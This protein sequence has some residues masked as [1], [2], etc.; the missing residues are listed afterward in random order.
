MSFAAVLDHTVLYILLLHIRPTVTTLVSL[1]D[2][3]NH[4]KLHLARLAYCEDHGLGVPEM[5]NLGMDT[6][7]Y[8]CQIFVFIRLQPDPGDTPLLLSQPQ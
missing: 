5:R 6:G 7:W 1:K 8:A 4:L 2:L 3:H